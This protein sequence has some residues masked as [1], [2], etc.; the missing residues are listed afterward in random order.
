MAV[1]PGPT[2]IPYPMQSLSLFEAVFRH[3]PIGNYLLSPTPEATVL[4][5]NDAFLR[6]SGRRREDLLGIS[7]FEAFPRNPD[8]PKDTG[9]PPVKSIPCPPSATR[10]ACSCPTAR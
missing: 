7:L 10:S 2:F 3:S 4:A 1:Q 5:V 6:A 8:D 9:E